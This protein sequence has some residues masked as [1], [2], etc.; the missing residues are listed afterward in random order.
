MNPTN[1]PTPISNSL[2]EAVGTYSV[3]VARTGELAP[4][5]KLSESF[6][7]I[8]QLERENVELK[9]TIANIT[10][11]KSHLMEVI[12]ERDK[13][14]EQFHRVSQ[15]LETILHRC[16]ELADGTSDATPLEKFAN[17]LVGLN[18][19]LMLGDILSMRQELAKLREDYKKLDDAAYNL[20]VKYQQEMIMFFGH[21]KDCDCGR[22][23]P[24]YKFLNARK[25]IIDAAK[26]GKV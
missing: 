21:A 15:N 26:K 10:A 2:I 22:C 7:A 20:M 17:E 16:C 25:Q 12:D 8:I 1:S 6:N 19:S 18:N 3:Q 24:Y 5:S 9:A 11:G 4:S 13:L 23:Y 14:K